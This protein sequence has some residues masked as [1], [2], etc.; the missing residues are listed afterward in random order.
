V[1]D[2]IHPVERRHPLVSLQD[3]GKRYVKYEDTPIL[4]SSVL[5]MRSKTRRSKLWAVRGVSLEVDAGETVGVIGRN[6]SG[7]S[8]LLRMLAGVSA[9]TEGALEV[10]GRVSPLISV[11]V[12]FHQE[13]TGREN[14]YVNGT[15]LGLTRSQISERFDQ[16][17]EFADI[18]E[19][20]DTPVKFYSSGMFVRLGFAVA[21]AAEPDVL[22]VD[23]VL[24]VGDIGFQAKCFVRMGELQDAGSTILVVS[25]NLGAIRNMCRRVLVLHDGTPRFLGDTDEAISLYHE[26]VAQSRSDAPGLEGTPPVAFTDFALLNKDGNRTSHI[27]G[28]EE[29]TF[30]VRIRPRLPIEEP[31]F[32]LMIST[33]AGMPVYLDN[34]WRWAGQK[35]R[36][37][38]GEEVLCE[39][40]VS[41]RLTTGSYTAVAGLMWDRDPEKQL[42]TLPLYFY[43]SAQGT[44]QGLV[45]LGASF[46]VRQAPD[47]SADA[48]ADATEDHS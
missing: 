4:L 44:A 33:E 10:R 11:G 23:E 45:D 13:L 42:S 29:V 43:I 40:R 25:H 28:N 34:N 20:I 24:A 27:E 9:P 46:D 48:S 19:F 7:K 38:P 12:G 16:I 47:A 32:S 1:T 39:I 31:V 6:G 14:V 22:L 36:S 2:D 26:L 18:G 37:G 30:Q 3:V 8:T 5:R 41:A 21:I 15:V 17:V 35:V